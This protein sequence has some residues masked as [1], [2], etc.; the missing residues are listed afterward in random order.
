MRTWLY[1][2]TIL[3]FAMHTIIRFLF[4][5]GHSNIIGGGGNNIVYTNK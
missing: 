2:L 3:M 5:I 1:V 4:L